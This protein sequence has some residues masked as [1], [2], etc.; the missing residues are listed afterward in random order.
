MSDSIK[1]RITADLQQAKSE[2]NLR[3]ERIREIVREAVAQAAA[4][5]QEG[6]AEI[7]A[8]AK[9][10]ISAAIETLG[11]KGKETK[12]REELDLL[13]QQ[14]AK[15]KAQLAVLEANLAACYGE[16]YEEVKQHL[17]SARTWYENTKT[18]MEA[19]G[20]NP[21][22]QK[23]AEFENK[24]GEVGAAAARKERQLKQL[25]KELWQAATKL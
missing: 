7:R 24:I 3:A 1:E 16:R 10:A 17:E 6:S 4:E 25:L 11:E 23:Q 20:T 5:F 2:G 8:I 22:E 21:V 12:D 19:S 9:D 13:R 14:Y 18:D 15:L